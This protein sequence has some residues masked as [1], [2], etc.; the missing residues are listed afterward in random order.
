MWPSSRQSQSSMCASSR[1]SRQ[2]PIPSSQKPMR[3]ASVRGSVIGHALERVSV[4]TQGLVQPPLGDVQNRA[5]PLLVTPTNRRFD[6]PF[7]LRFCF[8]HFK[9][10]ISVRRSRSPSWRSKSSRVR[11]ASCCQQSQSTGLVHRPSWSAMVRTGWGPSHPMRR[12]RQAA[13]IP[14]A[15]VV[16]SVGRSRCLWG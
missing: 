15:P 8:T 1:S 9:S 12:V 5:V 10:F 7:D 16:R 6:N 14:A 2:K 3:A 13:P 11:S 4:V